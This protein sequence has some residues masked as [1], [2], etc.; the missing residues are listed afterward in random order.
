MTCSGA[1]KS[2][3]SLAADAEVLAEG[4]L[5]LGSTPAGREAGRCV[6]VATRHED[7]LRWMRRAGVVLHAG[8][9]VYD[10]L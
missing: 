9:D 6:A 10:Q 1:L 3:R 5:A 4:V 8:G 7:A 2:N